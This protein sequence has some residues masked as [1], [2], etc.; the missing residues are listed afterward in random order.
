M[1][2][3]FESLMCKAWKSFGNHPWHAETEASLSAPQLW[4]GWTSWAKALWVDDMGDENGKSA[5]KIKGFEG[6]SN[7]CTFNRVNMDH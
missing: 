3:Y 2:L 7:L 1:Q 6:L 4:H 5:S